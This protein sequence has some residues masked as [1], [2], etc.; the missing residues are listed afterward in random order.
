LVERTVTVECYGSILYDEHESYTQYSDW[1]RAAEHPLEPVLYTVKPLTTVQRY[2]KILCYG[3]YQ[4][5][6]C[7]I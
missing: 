5:M 3:E 7:T 6:Y 1:R 4:N 2:V